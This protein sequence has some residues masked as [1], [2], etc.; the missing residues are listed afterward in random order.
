MSTD[1]VT[2]TRELREKVLVLC[3]ACSLLLLQY[4]QLFDKIASYLPTNMA[5]PQEFPY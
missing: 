2:G 1:D 5:A 3:T 4:L